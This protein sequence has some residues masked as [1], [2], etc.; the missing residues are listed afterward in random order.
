MPVLVAQEL[1]KSFGERRILD[2]VS[3][4]IHSG[5]HVGLVGANGS[6]KSTLARILAGLDKPDTG[7]VAQRR[8]ADVAYLSQEPA[9][10]PVKTGRELVVDGLGPWAAAKARYE[11]IS[12][13]LGHGDG[14]QDALLAEQAEVAAQIERL[15]GWDQLHK[16][17]EIIG[18]V[19]VTRPDAPTAE[20]SGGDKRRVALACLLIAPP[21][22]LV[23]DEPSNHLDTETIDWLERWLV[24]EYKGA[25]LIVT[26]DRYLLDRVVDRTIELHRGKVYS[27]EGGY[28]DYLEAKAERLAN[29]ART[30]QNRQNLLRT[31]LEWL[32][33]QPKARSTKQKARIQRA[34][35]AK[36]AT[37]ARA[38]QTTKLL[39][40]SSFTGKTVLELRK[41]TL[42]MAGRTLVKDFDFVLAAGERVGIVGRNGTGKT[43][44]LRSILGDVAPARGEVVVGKNTRVGYFDQHRSGLDE[45]KSIYDNVASAGNKIELGGQPIE[46]RSFLERFLFDGHAQRQP[47]KSLSGGERARVVLAKMLSQSHSLL[48]LDEPTND[49]DLPTL[50]ALEEMLTE[51]G[52]SA[53]VVTHDRWFLDRVATSLLVFE[54]DGRVVRYAGGHQDY[55]VQKAASEA[56]KEEAA[57]GAAATAKVAN[58]DKPS[59]AKPVAPKSK[60]LTWN[61]QRELDGIMGRIEEAEG[62]VASLEKE[63]ADPA[64]YSSRGAEVPVLGRRLDEAKARASTLIARWEELEQKQA[65]V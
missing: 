35:A 25:L 54:G 43:T 30:E 18:H 62:E 28:E 11:A 36:A 57:K 38:E 9:L 49:L 6:G 32:R 17:D 47:V 13:R 15:G 58:K 45:D 44:L 31:E 60:G 21:A 4:S 29:E 19:G 26:H 56:A 59:A 5:E 12:A 48:I 61:E 52:G 33:R 23:L 50:S 40:E 55:L 22:L 27:Y 64:L 3:L 34:E 37:P 46:V 63:L 2:G 51:Y 53:L 41:L 10:D 16:V 24:E 65:G 14:D 7:T 1:T 8:G 42:E 39:A 20:L